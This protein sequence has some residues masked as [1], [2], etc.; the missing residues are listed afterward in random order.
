MAEFLIFLAVAYVFIKFLFKPFILK[1][2]NEGLR[3]ER[4]S[5]QNT[6]KRKSIPIDSA[7]EKGDKFEKYIVKKF[8]TSHFT[9][10]EWRGD[11]YVDGLYAESNLNPDLELEF[12][13]NNFSIRF[14]LECKYRQDLYNGEIEIAKERQLLHY[15]LFEKEKQISVYIALG[16]GGT[17]EYPS[18]LFLIPLN[19]L[20]TNKISYNYLSKFKKKSNEQFYFNM[21]DKVLY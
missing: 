3:G 8:D 18:E 7:K 11:K 1:P 12:K 16:L 9:I 10:K 6:T 2:F 21:A 19:H 4:K 15:K 20:E 14:A 13:L 5:K 17:P